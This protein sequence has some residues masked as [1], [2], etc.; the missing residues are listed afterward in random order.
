MNTLFKT[1]TTSIK[2]AAGGFLL[3]I[4]LNSLLFAADE[5]ETLYNQTCVVCHGQGMH[6]APMPGVKTDWEQRL[7]YGIEDVYLNAIE[8]LGNTMPARGMCNDCTDKQIKSI[9]DFMVKEAK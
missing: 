3:S 9:V 5:A 7:S 4:S 1:T 2:C 6:G 8:G